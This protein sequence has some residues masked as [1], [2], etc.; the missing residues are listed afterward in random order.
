MGELRVCRVC[1]RTR[2]A[3]EY[4][5]AR[6]L[7]QQFV[8]ELCSAQGITDSLTQE[9]E[10]VIFESHSAEDK[11]GVADFDEL[12]EIRTTRL[13]DARSREES[14]IATLSDRISIELEKRQLVAG[15]AKQIEDK[16]QLISGYTKDRSKLASKGS[17]ERVKQLTE[18]TTA[19]EKV[20]SYP[21][22][23]AAQEQSLLS[24]LDE[25]ENVRTHQAPEGLRRTQERYK[26][27]ALQPTDWPPFLLDYKGDVD[28]CLEKH[29]AKCRDGAR[30][31]KGTPQPR[32]A[33]LTISRLLAN[34]SLDQ[35][36]LSQ[37][38]AEND[39]IEK[40]IRAESDHPVSS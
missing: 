24:L 27:S 5:R 4:P 14:A 33:D 37:L 10:R 11:D 39:R 26:A 31:W 25:V 29:L 16:Q 8:E 3:A 28:A 23:F 12:L 32:N 17:E 35:Q 36:P 22:F 21:R 20:R 38:E 40:Q 2:S 1:R 7:S 13:R 9:M 30:S 15:L 6:Y 34:A 19:A 18:L